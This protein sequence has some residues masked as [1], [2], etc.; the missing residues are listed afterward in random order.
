MVATS[1]PTATAAGLRVLSRGGNAVDAAVAAAAALC[2]TEPM[3]TG[4]GGDLF[5]LVFTDG[6]VEGLD[7]AGPAPRGA[8]PGQPAAQFGP[9]SITVPGAVAG[10]AALAERYGRL[11]LEACLEDAVELASGGF[12]VGSRCAALW[13]AAAHVP[14]QFQ[15]VPRPGCRV[16]LPDL[17]RTLADIACNGPVAFYQGRVGEAICSASWLEEADL[18]AFQP[19]WVTPLEVSYEGHTVLEMPPPAQGIAALEGLALLDRTERTLI[20]R[21][22]CSRLAL[23]DALREVRDGAD[24][25]HLL[26]PANVDRRLADAPARLTEPGGGTVYL[27]A[28]DADGMAVS[29]VQ[30]LFEGFGSGVV[31]ADTGVVLQ[32]RGACFS[33]NGSVEPGR[34]PY[35]TIIPGMISK[36]GCL[37]GPFGVMGGFVQAQA[38]LQLVHGLLSDGLDPQAALDRPRFR[39]E[40]DRLL[41]E[42][43][44]WAVAPALSVTGL[45]PVL[46]QD[47]TH[48]GGGQAIMRT[49]SG[50]LIGGSDSRKDGCAVGW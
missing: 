38:H 40:G 20:D 44:L 34:R 41:L 43:G 11:G 45:R 10:W 32:N 6:R 23:E 49:S 30:S 35:H 50:T 31:A 13:A 16:A 4:P 29:L 9:R 18:T 47:R 15:P 33:V 1:Q 14:D 24:V 36:D 12:A 7:A 8:S 27:C 3:S 28:V 22:T 2:V 39:V 19:R 21:I 42:K 17:A 37:L 26:D 46:E 48:F 25:G 5:A